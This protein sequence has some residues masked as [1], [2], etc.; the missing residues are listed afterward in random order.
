MRAGHRL[1]LCTDGLT[2]M[3]G[4]DQVA[5]L[6]MASDPENAAVDLIAAANDAGGADNITVVVVEAV[7]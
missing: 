6:L 5:D 3:V 4:D 2:N 7:T 1:L